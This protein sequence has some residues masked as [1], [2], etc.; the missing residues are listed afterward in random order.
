MSTRTRPAT[1]LVAVL[2]CA[3]MLTAC[4]SLNS[5]ATSPDNSKTRRGAGIGAASGVVV[6]LLTSG[7]SLQ[8]ALIG[9]AVGGLA[10]GAIGNYQ[11]RQERQLRQ[12]M[13]N[14]GVE[15]VRQGDNI[16]LGMPGQVTFATSSADITADFKPILNSVASTLV[17][18]NQ[19]LIEVAG[20][21]DSTGSREYNQALSVRRAESVAVHLVSQGVP[22][23][24]IVTVGA[25]Q[26]HPVADNS[27]TE[28]RQKNRRVEMTIVPIEAK[29]SR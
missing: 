11:D 3:A 9:A 12:Q 29:A 28:G 24:R 19:T 6:G 10:G 15:V 14:T 26:D 20:H 25:G 4:E 23:N 17:E 2:A 22:R 27:T 7:G 16:T 21:T 8:G 5:L 18:F 13:A 1:L